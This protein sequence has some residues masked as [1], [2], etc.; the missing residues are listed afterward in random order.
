MNVRY[1]AALLLCSLPAGLVASAATPDAREYNAWPAIVRQLESGNRAGSWTGAGPFLFKSQEPDGTIGG[2]RPFWVQWRGGQGEFRAGYFLY[3]LFGYTVGADSYKWSLFELVRRGGRRAGAPAPDSVY[4][5]RGEFEV[6]PFWFS[7]QSGDPALTY[8]GLFPIA[9]TVRNKLFMERFSWVLFPLYGEIERRGTVTRHTPWPIIRSR[10][11]AAQGWGIWPLF[12]RYERP[13]VARSFHYLWPL[14]YDVTRFPS[15]DAPPDTPPRRDTGFLPFYARTTGPGLYNVTY[16]WPFFGYTDQT[17]PTKYHETRYFWPFLVQGRGDDLHVNRWGPF[18]SHSIRKGYDK[19][20]YAWPLLRR[21]QWTDEGLLRTKTQFLYF[22]YVAHH[23]R[24][25][26]RPELPAG[27]LTHVWPFFSTWNN[28]AGR[29]QWQLLSPFE[30]FFP[31][32][33]KLRHVWAPFFTLARHDQHAPGDT[34]TSL[35]WD[36]VT[37]RR[38]DAADHREF[39]L[40]PLFSVTEQSGARRVAFGN[41]LFGFQRGGSAGGW[42]LFWLDFPAKAA[43]TSDP[44]G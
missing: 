11:G 36:A 35:L 18:Y 23:Q 12:D 20:W 16:G 30:S 40:G 42:R 3:P 22:L 14:G 6:W 37:W 44:S 24:S 38:D 41:G 39:H 13:G 10:H 9:G 1:F 8:R 21:A 34:R 33:E 32:N 28:G 43:T 17:L 7:R 26:A 15:P 27:T 31:G 19:R 5:Q 2:F 25:I 29:R 4:D